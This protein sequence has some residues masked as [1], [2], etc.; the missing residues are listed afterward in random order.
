MVYLTSIGLCC[1]ERYEREDLDDWIIQ[2]AA[3]VLSVVGLVAGIA[4]LRRRPAIA[5]AAWALAGAGNSGRRHLLSASGCRS[6]VP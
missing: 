6:S 5:N 3:L 4:A 2:G 1:P